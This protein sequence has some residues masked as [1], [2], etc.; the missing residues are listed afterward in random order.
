MKK[1]VTE[2]G[3]ESGKKKNEKKPSNVNVKNQTAKEGQT[4]V[5]LFM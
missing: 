2:V 4:V 3:E 1:M 5:L